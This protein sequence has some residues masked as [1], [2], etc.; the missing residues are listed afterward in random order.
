M[1]KEDLTVPQI[2][3]LLKSAADTSGF[4]KTSAKG[5][6]L[7]AIFDRWGNTVF[8]PVT[9]GLQDM[10]RHAR[11]TG[12]EWDRLKRKLEQKFS[13]PDFLK[14]LLRLGGI[15]SG[16]A[17]VE[18]V[19][20]KVRDHFREIAES[21][22][23]IVEA[24]KRLHELSTDVRRSRMSPEDLVAEDERE[25]AKANARIKQL[26]EIE[27]RRRMIHRGPE[28]NAASR[29]WTPAH[30]EEVVDHRTVKQ[31]EERARQLEL[32]TKLNEQ[33]EKNRALVREGTVSNAL[34]EFFGPLDAQSASAAAATEA[35]LQSTGDAAAEAER[36][37]REA[38][39]E[40]NSEL[41]DRA[42]IYKAMT[43]PFKTYK[44]QLEEITMLERMEKLNAEQAAAA[45]DR[46]KFEMAGGFTP[47]IDAGR[48][49]MHAFNNELAMLA[50]DKNLT[51][52][53]R[54]EKRVEILK[55]E[56]AEIERQVS[57]L[58]AL[59]AVNPGK[60]TK[61]LTKEIENLRNK[62]DAN[63]VDIASSPQS[64]IGSARL[65]QRELNDSSKHYQTAGEG[66]EGGLLG[67]LVKM[68]TV[69]DQ[70]AAGIENTIG[71]AVDGVTQGIMGWVNGT[72]TFGQALR[73]IGT[74]I[75]QTIL[76]TIIQMGAQMAINAALSK[77]FHRQE[78]TETK[79]EIGQKATA[80][81]M[82][83]IAQLGPIWGPVA[84]A[85]S[86]AA[87]FALASRFSEGGM[88]SGPGTSTS[89]SI[90]A[91]LS[92]GEAVLNARATSMLGAG[93]I[94]GLNAG[95]LSPV[96][97]LTRPLVRPDGVAAAAGGA[98]GGQSPVQNHY[99]LFDRAEWARMMQE[100]STGYFHDQMSRFMRRNA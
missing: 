90:P 63:N 18:T 20:G 71:A 4:D 70:I 72:M 85:A 44:D 24:T 83:S 1:E 29:M 7:Q 26:E 16:F 15:G 43:D 38:A 98:S 94:D 6:E 96:Q 5:R 51:D 93:V 80:G 37:G 31:N 69:A 36:R 11:E 62:Q 12:S 8:A 50:A 60:D 40:L 58:R 64:K 9:G 78:Q 91:W 23:K 10:Q 88:V 57:A 25:L 27:G 3:I 67:A 95:T 84:F 45:R 47:T 59:V 89:D 2:D 17:V 61:Q 22:Q 52:N 65:G 92:N 19:I 14:D 66:V 42:E 97:A 35:D 76:Q 34:G 53:E 68:G 30:D 32:R 39:E 74:S 77:L 82:K 48:E 73:N 33:L 81:G 28:Y 75:L 86:I 87:I 46:V 54:R 79:A 55:R 100:D 41:R 13:G 99:F 21:E 49:A 56:N